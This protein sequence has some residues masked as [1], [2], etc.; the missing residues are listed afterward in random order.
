M[1]LLEDVLLYKFNSIVF[2]LFKRAVVLLPHFC[3]INSTVCR[4]TARYDIG[5]IE[6]LILIEGENADGDI[7]NR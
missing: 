2:F 1:Y 6:V 3:E 4:A 5:L 7:E